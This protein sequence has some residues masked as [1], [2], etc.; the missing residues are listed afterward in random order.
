LRASGQVELLIK[1]DQFDSFRRLTG[2]MVAL[3]RSERGVLSYQPLSVTTVRRSR[4]TNGYAN[5]AVA[6][7]H[8]ETFKMRFA[9]RLEAMAV[10][11]PS[12]A[13]RLQRW[14]RSSVTVA[15]SI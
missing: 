4:P 8:L 11:S 6:L 2:E 10:N 13:S 3:A 9:A 14:R 1:P 12:L 15:R 5:S 7:V